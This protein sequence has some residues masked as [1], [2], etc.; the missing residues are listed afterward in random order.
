MTKMM[1]P[2]YDV[3]YGKT[4][5]KIPPGLVCGSRGACLD[6]VLPGVQVTARLGFFLCSGCLGDSDDSDS[7]L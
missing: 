5:K 1:M 4:Q 7:L 6:S 3:K 2:A